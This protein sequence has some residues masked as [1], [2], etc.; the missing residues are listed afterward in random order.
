M[1]E[2][3]EERKAYETAISTIHAFVSEIVPASQPAVKSPTRN[4]HVLEIRRDA[5]IPVQVVE[6]RCGSP[7]GPDPGPGGPASAELAGAGSGSD[8][9]PREKLGIWLDCIGES[10]GKEVSPIVIV[11]VTPGG[12]AAKDGRLRRGDQVLEING[13]SLSNVSLERAR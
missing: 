1:T 7:G 4:N 8:H 3:P 10:P 6:L 12:V 9:Q 13:R 5:S 2:N 11:Q